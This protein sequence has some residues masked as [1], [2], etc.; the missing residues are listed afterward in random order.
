LAVNGLNF[1]HLYL[2]GLRSAYVRGEALMA[3]HQYTEAAVE[4]QKILDHAVSW[5]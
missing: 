5:A 3:A 4:F 1:S 2:G